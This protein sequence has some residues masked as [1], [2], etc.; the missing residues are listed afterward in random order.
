MH[1]ELGMTRISVLGNVIDV[2]MATPHYIIH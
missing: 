1:H 2:L